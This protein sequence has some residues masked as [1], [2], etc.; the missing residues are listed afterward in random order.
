MRWG[1]CVSVLLGVLCLVFV[2]G[3]SK[4]AN[5]M[6]GNVRLN[7]ACLT[8]V[9]VL[10]PTNHDPLDNQGNPDG[11]GDHTGEM[12]DL[13]IE[14]VYIDP[15]GYS[16]T[17]HS[18]YYIGENMDYEIHI[19][20]LGNQ[21]FNCLDVSAE[22]QYYDNGN[23]QCGWWS[24]NPGPA[25]VAYTKGEPMPGLS[26]NNWNGVGLPPHSMVALK[27]SYLSPN[28]TASGI[29]QTAVLIK[30]CNTPGQCSEHDA[31]MYYDPE[32]GVFDPPGSQSQQLQ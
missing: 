6:G 27:G 9:A 1:R 20:N 23:C 10:T 11:Y 24:P 15:K 22:H 17:G 19:T 26:S 8:P 18:V 7:A 31:L 30:H 12:K 14:L 16:P 2:T 29:D 5:M 21:T 13:K 32:Q 4:S 25:G 3:C 28:N